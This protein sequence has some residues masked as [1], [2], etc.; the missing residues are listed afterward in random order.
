MR[1]FDE[2]VAEPRVFGEAP[3]KGAEVGGADAQDALRIDRGDDLRL[4]AA[5]SGIGQIGELIDD[6]LHTVSLLQ[7]VTQ[8]YDARGRGLAAGMRIRKMRN[9]FGDADFIHQ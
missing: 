5:I 7:V 3:G 4:K 8:V 9:A 1:E 2:E 6:A